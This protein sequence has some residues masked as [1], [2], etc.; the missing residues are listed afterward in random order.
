MRLAENFR[1]FN[2]IFNVIRSMQSSKC[3]K[4][5]SFILIRG[6]TC[7]FVLIWENAAPLVP[8]GTT[9]GHLAANPLTAIPIKKGGEVAVTIH[10]T[11]ATC[12]CSDVQR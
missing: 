5:D 9:T 12:P 11:T 2:L 7:S 4:P 8:S 10:L 1:S 6:D 3:V